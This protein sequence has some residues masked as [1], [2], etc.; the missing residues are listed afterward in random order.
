VIFTNAQ[1]L[2]PIRFNP[3][4]PD[5]APESQGCASLTLVKAQ[6]LLRSW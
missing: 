2:E 6:K 4:S 3:A 1:A 5:D